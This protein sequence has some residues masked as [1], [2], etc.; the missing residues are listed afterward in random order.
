MFLDKVFGRVSS[1]EY[2]NSRVGKFSQAFVEN[3]Q[4][5]HSI[6]YTC[7]RERVKSRGKVIGFMLRYCVKKGK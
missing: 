1:L 7:N 6:Q 5:R 4:S 3:T 2:L